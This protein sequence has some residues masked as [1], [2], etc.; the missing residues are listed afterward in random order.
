MPQASESYRKLAGEPS[1]ELDRLFAS[2]EPPSMDALAGLE[3]RGFNKPWF[4]SLFGIRKFIKAFFTTDDGSRFGRNTPVEQNGLEG[5]WVAKPD[6]ANPKRF[7]FFS[8]ASV[9]PSPRK[10][11]PHALLFDYGQGHNAWY[12]LSRFL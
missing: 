12:Q 2:G 11:H 8:V 9:D 4:A 10:R 1:S 7:G 5:D 6:D 3:L